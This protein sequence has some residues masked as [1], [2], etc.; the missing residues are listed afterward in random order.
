MR[1]SIIAT[2]LL[3]SVTALPVLANDGVELSAK[4]RSLAVASAVTPSK[5]AEAPFSAAGRDPLPEL[6]VLPVLL[7]WSA[8]SACVC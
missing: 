4:A 2:A 3:A 5:L 7:S 8:V 6:L 1:R